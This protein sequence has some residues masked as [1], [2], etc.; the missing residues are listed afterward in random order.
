MRF[1]LKFQR[2][3]TKKKKRKIFIHPEPTHHFIF[4]IN[5]NNLVSFQINL[6]DCVNILLYKTEFESHFLLANRTELK[7]NR[8]FARMLPF[9]NLSSAKKKNTNKKKLFLLRPNE[10]LPTSSKMKKKK[11]SFLRC[12]CCCL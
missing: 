7:T 12:R 11:T 4:E 10:K 3:A 5:K 2:K 6:F 1:E 9:A 8:F